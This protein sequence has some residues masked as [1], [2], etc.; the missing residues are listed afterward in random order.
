[1]AYAPPSLIAC[2]LSQDA[3]VW[4]PPL[5]APGVGETEEHSQPPPAQRFTLEDGETIQLVELLAHSSEQSEQMTC[6]AGATTADDCVSAKMRQ[7]AGFSLYTDAGRV[8]SVGV[9]PTASAT[10]A[11]SG[12]LSIVSAPTG[13]A[14]VALQ[15]LSMPA[16]ADALESQRG[17]Q[18]HPKTSSG[19]LQLQMIFGRQCNADEDDKGSNAFDTPLERSLRID[20]PLSAMAA[21]AARRRRTSSNNSSWPSRLEWPVPGAPE[22]CTVLCEAITHPDAAQ[23]ELLRQLCRIA[24]EVNSRASPTASPRSPA[25]SHASAS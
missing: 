13:C 15:G 11:S 10:A 22:F 1:V 12:T 6:D 5:D 9:V 3:L 2:T 16:P 21:A 8:F 7:L 24:E 20:C 14:L 19:L 18:Q 23:Q 25:C 4:A 17:A